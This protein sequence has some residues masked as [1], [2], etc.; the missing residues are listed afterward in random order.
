MANRLLDIMKVPNK[1][2][3]METGKEIAVIG[4]G[5]EL[6]QAND[7]HSYWKQASEGISSIGE[8]PYARKMEAES[9]A[10][11]RRM[12]R[13]DWQFIRQGYLRRIDRFDYRFFGMSPR[14]AELTDPHQ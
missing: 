4:L 8:L 14:E 5:L 7:A 12:A 13:S 2:T 11:Y 6:P 9:F 10:R 1:N 3:S